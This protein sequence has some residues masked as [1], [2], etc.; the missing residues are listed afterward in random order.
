MPMTAD[1]AIDAIAQ[2]VDAEHHLTN[3]EA[4]PHTERRRVAEAAIR[5]A[6]AIAARAR[7]ELAQL[8]A[9]ISEKREE[10]KFH[11]LAHHNHAHCG[12]A[13]NATYHAQRRNAAEQKWL[14]ARRVM[15][16]VKRIIGEEE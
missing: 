13:D 1:E 15:E 5:E 2:Q 3:E 7:T 11:A 16:T 9:L 8:E 6:F 14:I 4:A 12:Y 10:I